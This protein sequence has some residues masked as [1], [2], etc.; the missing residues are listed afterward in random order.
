MT[1]DQTVMTILA[2]AAISAWTVV[3]AILYGCFLLIKRFINA[4][5]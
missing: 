3:S 5:R 2:F 1:Y 4:K